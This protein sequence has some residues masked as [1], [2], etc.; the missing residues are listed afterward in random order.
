MFA[1]LLDAGM[2]APQS[3]AD[4]LVMNVDKDT[5]AECLNIATNLREAGINTEFYFETAKMDKQFKYAEKK[6]VKVA[7][8]Y[9]GNEAKKKQ[10]VVKDLSQKKQVAVDQDQL[11]TQVKSMLW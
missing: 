8:I 9:G 6:N 2:V 7:V 4:V 5:I 10:V 1:A 3:T 11:V